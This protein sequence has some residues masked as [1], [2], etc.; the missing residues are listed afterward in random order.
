LQTPGDCQKIVCTGSGGVTSA[1]DAT[2]LPVSNTTC[3][4][5]PACVGPSPLTPAFTPTATGTDC[6]ADGN[7][8]NHVCGDTSNGSIA[9][10]RVE[11]NVDADCNFS[12]ATTCNTVTGTCQ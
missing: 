12:A 10:V 7:P 5:N 2:D 4:T 6:S 8:P 9:G 1:D 3:L 11:C